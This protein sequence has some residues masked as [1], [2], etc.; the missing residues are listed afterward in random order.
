MTKAE[1]NN[2]FEVIICTTNSPGEKWSN[3]L[4]HNLTWSRFN[5]DVISFRSS[6]WNLHSRRQCQGCCDSTFPADVQT[7]S[8]S[9]WSDVCQTNECT[10]TM[11]IVPHWV[12]GALHV[13]PIY[14]WICQALTIATMLQ[15]SI[16][17]TC[18]NIAIIV[19]QRR[20][21]TTGGQPCWKAYT[22]IWTSLLKKKKVSIF[23]CTILKR[24]WTSRYFAH[25]I[26]YLVRSMVVPLAWRMT[27][28]LR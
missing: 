9:P 16:K 6:D 11:S 8:H 15:K 25:F 14:C 4:A 23:F 22:R 1:E 27:I 12:W 7:A 5:W 28:S 26:T 21:P 3:L 2:N 17:E 24:R 18:I 20:I 13:A 10:E 19:W